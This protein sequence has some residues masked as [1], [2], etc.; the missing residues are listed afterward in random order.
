VAH[1]RTMEEFLIA[2]GA[3]G[4][5]VARQQRTSRRQATAVETAASRT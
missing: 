4:P 1:G 3:G 5:A 2:L